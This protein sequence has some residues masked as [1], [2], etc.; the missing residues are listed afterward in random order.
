MPNIGA[1]SWIQAAEVCYSAHVIIGL[2]QDSAVLLRFLEGE[3]KEGVRSQ[4]ILQDKE[5][6]KTGK[7]GR[8]CWEAGSVQLP[9]G[10]P[11]HHCLCWSFT[12]QNSSELQSD[13]STE[14][15]QEVAC[16]IMGKFISSVICSK[17]EPTWQQSAYFYHLLS[18][19]TFCLIKLLLAL[20]RCHKCYMAHCMKFDIS[21]IVHGLLVLDPALTVPD[22]ISL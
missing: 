16:S 3:M 12:L 11:F 15:M 7:R 20:S 21:V 17:W 18:D 19:V 14:G 6:T 1:M 4:G 8:H 22:T 5:E 9:C 2:S 13:A 10:H